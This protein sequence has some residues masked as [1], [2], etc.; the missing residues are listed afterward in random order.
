[1]G[2]GQWLLGSIVRVRGEG[3]YDVKYES[4]GFEEKRVSESM[5][6]LKDSVN[7]QGS[8]SETGTRFGLA[9]GNA[10]TPVVPTTKYEVGSEVECNFRGAGQ[11]LRARITRV[12]PD[13]LCDVE[14]SADGRVEFRVDSNRLRDVSKEEEVDANV[15]LEA[16][17]V[18]PEAKEGPE[19]SEEAKAE[20]QQELLDV[21]DEKKVGESKREE[22]YEYE[23]DVFEA[24]QSDIKMEGTAAQQ[25]DEK[26][27]PHEET[28]HEPID[29]TSS[30]KSK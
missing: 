1:M 18:S 6:R 13:G 10:A 3:L 7:K 26:H 2:K 19:S 15:D 25:P 9:D 14:L 29:A 24:A 20:E 4:D 12:R 28:K 27:I 11:W 22:D 17:P 8:Q 30:A 5:I 16:A 23:E 21:N